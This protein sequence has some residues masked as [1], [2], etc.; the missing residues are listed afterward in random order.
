MQ[1][2]GLRVSESAAVF[3]ENRASIEVFYLFFVKLWYNE[4]IDAVSKR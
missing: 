4:G 2:G 1:Y 3:G